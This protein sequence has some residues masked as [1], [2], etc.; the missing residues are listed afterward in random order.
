MKAGDEGGNEV[1]TKCQ[2]LPRVYLTRIREQKDTGM[3]NKASSSH[4]GFS[5]RLKYKIPFPFVGERIIE[6]YS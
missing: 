5:H 4:L 1:P 3:L 6:F 2:V